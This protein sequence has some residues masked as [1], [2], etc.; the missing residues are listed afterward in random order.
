[1]NAYEITFIFLEENDNFEQ[2]FF[3]QS[4]HI[5]HTYLPSDIVGKR[6]KNSS[7]LGAFN[8]TSSVVSLYSVS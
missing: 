7:Q 8:Y 3:T 4:M 2:Q 1:M 5:K 6:M